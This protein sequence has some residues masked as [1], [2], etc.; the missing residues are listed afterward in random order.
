MRRQRAL[1]PLATYADCPALGSLERTDGVIDH[2]GPGGLHMVRGYVY[3]GETFRVTAHGRPGK[4][5]IFIVHILED[6]EEGGEISLDR[7]EDKDN[8]PEETL[9]SVVLR[10]T[11]KLIREQPINVSEP[12]AG[13]N[14]IEANPAVKVHDGVQHH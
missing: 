10:L 13:L 11:E 8:D 6:D 2:K 5:E 12:E 9:E 7:F 3:R 14:W 1:T 4:E